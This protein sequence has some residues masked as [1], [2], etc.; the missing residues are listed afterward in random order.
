MGIGARFFVQ[1][2]VAVIAALIFL[3]PLAI[4]A[5]TY[6][7]NNT[8]DAGPGT[9]RQAIADANSNPG[10]DTINFNIPGPGPLAINLATGLPAI[11]DTVV[12]DGT[13]ELA[14]NPA[15]CAVSP[16]ITL[17][18]GGL[19]V[20]AH[21][22]DIH[23]AGSTIKGLAIGNFAGQA[24]IN[25]AGD[26]NIVQGNYIGTDVSGTIA[27]P[28]GFGVLVIGSYAN[29][30]IGG[31]TAVA[32][33]VVSGNAEDGI[34][35]RNLAHHN[36]VRGNYVG[37]TPAGNSPLGNANNGIVLVFGAHDN[38][39]GGTVGVT[40]W[41][42]CAGACNLIS[43]DGIG[44]FIANELSGQ[45]S[46]N[47]IVQGN[48]IGT[49]VTGTSAIGNRNGV[50][51]AGARNN[52]IGGPNPGEGNLISANNKEPGEHRGIE[53]NGG[54][55]A[56][57]LTFGNVVQGN[58]IGTRAN[59]TSPLGHVYEGILIWTGAF[60]NTI[61]GTTGTTP[62]GQCTGACNIIAFNGTISFN[63]LGIRIFEPS[64]VTGTVGN[65]ISRNSIFSNAKGGIDL[66]LDL[67]TPN[68]FQDP[69]DGPNHLQNSPLI[70]NSTPTV[71]GTLNSTPGRSF[72]IEFFTDPAASNPQGKTFRGSTTVTANASGDASFNVA[73]PG[74]STGDYL[75]AT[76]T[77]TTTNDTSEFSN[78][79][80]ITAPT[81][82]SSSISGQ[83][84]TAD[85]LPLPGVVVHL[86]GAHSA[87]TITDAGGNYLFDNVDTNN[88]YTVTPSRLNYHFDPDSRSFSLLGNQTDAVFT[89]DA[90]VIIV[91]NAIDTAEYFVR[92]HYLDFLGREPDETGF[93]FWSDQ[94]L[95]C[96]SDNACI[97]RRTI[98]VSAAYF[99]SIEFQ[100]TGG[101][102]DGLYRASYAHA[103]R[104]AEF[105][106]DTALVARDV[107]VGRAN[108]AQQLE[109]NK[110]AFVAA[111][112]E[113]ADFRAAYDGL[114]SDAF[115]DSLISHAGAGFN[116][117]RAAL[118]RGLNSGSLSRAEVLRRVVENEGFVNAKHNEMFVMMEYFGYLRR[119][120]D[121]S[122]YQ[123][124]LDK[125]NRFDGNFEEAE[126]VK[127]FINSGEYRAR[128]PR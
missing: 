58:R 77:D 37:T 78:S 67:N 69:D 35:I 11:T 90:N 63:T 54:A 126:M 33:N 116:G 3:A 92:Q 85:S 127:A 74:L 51:I 50:Q 123:F 88:F 13:S 93:N 117:N 26:A 22:L 103:P 29:N 81:A 121:E 18:G 105:M 119:D 46:E 40:S 114:G 66:G 61:G 62:G 44:V 8:G 56:G 41:S 72:V 100:Q 118:V 115:V 83:V 45:Q 6:L 12:I 21:G 94:I 49:D 43:D 120:P 20:Q 87:R 76:A 128:F 39:V 108:W 57:T 75:V 34:S 64:G 16:C 15:V 65:L 84:L 32:R 86:S 52:L 71:K 1:P 107:I 7:V 36:T 82:S 125:L 106:P 19:S 25:I 17:D 101:L 55:G 109:A 59:G 42:G 30:L 27:K 122:G 4:R 9:L 24:G 53:I 28:N 48:Y 98:N 95:S 70:T 96:G 60:G 68:D 110:Q 112:V 31:T 97:E 47:N 73:L 113:R 124:W 104:Y 99:L 5:N 80:R 91:G 14:F 10:L 89:A 2:R 111:W 102:I 38:V 23:T 79:F